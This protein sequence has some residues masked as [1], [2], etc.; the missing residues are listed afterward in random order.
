[1]KHKKKKNQTKNK[2][3]DFEIKIISKKLWLLASLRLLAKICQLPLDL[4]GKNK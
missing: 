3:V 4:T 1:M 2:E